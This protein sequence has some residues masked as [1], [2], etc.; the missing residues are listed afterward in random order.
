MM[1]SQDEFIGKERIGLLRI[2][3]SFRMARAKQARMVLAGWLEE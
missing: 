1:E 2:G 3:I